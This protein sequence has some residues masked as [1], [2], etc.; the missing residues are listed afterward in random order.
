MDRTLPTKPPALRVTIG[1]QSIPKVCEIFED[2][3][4]HQGSTEE[5]PLMRYGFMLEGEI[6]WCTD[7][8]TVKEIARLARR[9][10]GWLKR[11][12][13]WIETVDQVGDR[14][15]GRRKWKKR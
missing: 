13:D 3:A 14:C 10:S 1:N 8:Y 15:H 6:I 7:D 9:V 12:A 4:P 11:F 2:A 5:D